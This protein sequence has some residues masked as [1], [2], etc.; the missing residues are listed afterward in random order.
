MEHHIV[1]KIV[2]ATRTQIA[3]TLYCTVLYCTVMYCTVLYCIVLYHLVWA[4]AR[5][6]AGQ[7]HAEAPGVGGAGVEGVPG[8]RP[9]R[10]ARPRLRVQLLVAVAVLP[11]QPPAAGRCTL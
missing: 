9:P 4:D 1:T 3:C 8:A 2:P 7:V 5:V 10:V 6:W 11:V